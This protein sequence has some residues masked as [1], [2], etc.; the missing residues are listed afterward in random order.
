M[1]SG[2]VKLSDVQVRSWFS[3][4]EQSVEQFRY[5]KDRSV[6]FGLGLV[7]RGSVWSCAG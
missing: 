3:L 1:E 2:N 4:V 7:L 5:G 6:I